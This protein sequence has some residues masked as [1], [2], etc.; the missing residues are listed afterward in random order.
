MYALPTALQ[1]A[2]SYL[3]V[4]IAASG[5]EIDTGPP[6]VSTPEMPTPSKVRLSK[7]EGMSIGQ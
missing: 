4:L 7:A 3:N 5:P 1:C 2:S 6:E